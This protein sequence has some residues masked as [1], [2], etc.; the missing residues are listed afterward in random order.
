M[1]LTS[2]FINSMQGVCSQLC[3]VDLRLGNTMT[4][5]CCLGEAWEASRNRGAAGFVWE[6]WLLCP[7]PRKAF[8][9][10]G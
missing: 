10:C 3:Q 2:C 7:D 4:L 6:G 9:E 1:G 5:S 8:I